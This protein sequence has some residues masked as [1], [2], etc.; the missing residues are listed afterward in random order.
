VIKVNL[1][2]EHRGGAKQV[3]VFAAETGRKAGVQVLPVVLAGLLLGG[4]FYYWT[5]R[6]LGQ[7][8]EQINQKQAEKLRLDAIIKEVK[9]YEQR[10]L[11]LEA[12]ISV[13]QQLKAAQADQV[14]LLIEIGR[15]VPQQVE[16]VSLKEANANITIE[17]N[18]A[19]NNT[20]SEFMKRIE[21]S[22]YF[23]DLRLK[24]SQRMPNFHKFSL[25]CRYNP[26]P[27]ASAPEAN[28]AAASKRHG[29]PETGHQARRHRGRAA[30][31]GGAGGGDRRRTAVLLRLALS[32][33]RKR[34]ARQG[35]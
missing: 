19:N 5:E 21:D 22:P 34:P 17:G 18:A 24:D 12:R 20:L 6:Q 11:Q 26:H 10:K 33:P 27:G 35:R 31:G 23:S 9:E 8:Q 32:G 14:S 30:V 7:L 25:T 15:Y 29:R 3:K 1:L 2:K 16:L 4:G 13:V 28:A